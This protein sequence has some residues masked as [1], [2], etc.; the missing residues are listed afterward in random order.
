MSDGT[1]RVYF[2]GTEEVIEKLILL[3]CKTENFKQ[4]KVIEKDAILELN[5]VDKK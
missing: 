5:E 1:T 4:L 3:A 2:E